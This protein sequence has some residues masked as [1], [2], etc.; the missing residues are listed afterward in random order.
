[1]VPLFYASYMPKWYIWLYH[2]NQSLSASWGLQSSP[3]QLEH[4]A[5]LHRYSLQI[6][7]FSR[8]TLNYEELHLFWVT[9]D[10]WTIDYYFLYE[11]Q[12]CSWG[13]G[14]GSGNKKLT[15]VG[16]RDTSKLRTVHLAADGDQVETIGKLN[17][18]GKELAT[19][20]TKLSA[21]DKFTL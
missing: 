11:Y 20:P 17:R 18:R 3:K 19:L 10:Y 13:E 6:R 1:M 15:T 14:E 5:N 7:P 16:S 8:M 21:K 12:H 9:S 4:F 2:F